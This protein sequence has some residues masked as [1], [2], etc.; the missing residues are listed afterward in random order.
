MT[1][2]A[3][4]KGRAGCG[5]KQGAKYIDRRRFS[6]AVGSQKTK[7]GV[8]LDFKGDSVDRSD[9]AKFLDK[10]ADTDYLHRKV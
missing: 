2:M 10:V 9:S 7:N 6:C 4:E 8:L 1:V 3:V 5:R